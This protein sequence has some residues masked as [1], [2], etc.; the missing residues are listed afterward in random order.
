MTDKR[1]KDCPCVK[2]NIHVKK[3]DRAFQCS[4]CDI[5]VHQKCTVPE[6]NPETFNLIV[7]Q[8]KQNGGTFWACISCR[9]FKAK[10]EKRLSSLEKWSV[11]ADE[12]IS[13]NTSKITALET[14]LNDLASAKKNEKPLVAQNIKEDASNAVLDELDEREKRKCNVIV[15]GLKEAANTVTDGKQRQSFDLENLQKIVSDLKLN[16][17]MASSL[18]FSRRLGKKS[19]D[20]ANRP[21]LLS[22]VKASDK[23]CLLEN[24]LKLKNMD[25]DFNEVSIVQDLTA[26]QR[27]AEKSLR[28][29]MEKLNSELGDEESKNWEWKVVGRRGDRK[30]VKRETLKSPIDPEHPQV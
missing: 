10:F 16:I 5:W 4:L 27:N 24:A 18:K 15:H 3:N 30:I 2:C 19:D 9:N 11:T 25:S 8:V 14:Q 28:T 22:F 1:K 26:K 23:D 17:D 6:M 7:A 21:F 29:Q 20:T 12:N 13:S